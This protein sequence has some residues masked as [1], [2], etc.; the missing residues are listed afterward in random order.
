LDRDID[1]YPD[2]FNF[3]VKFN[4][5]SSSILRTEV[6]KNGVKQTVNEKFRGAPR[7]HITKEFRNVKYIKLDNVVLP[8]FTKLEETYDGYD[9]DKEK[10]LVNDRFVS[11]VIKE[12]DTNRILCTSDDSIRIDEDTGEETT[13]PCP[14]AMIFPEKLLGTNFFTGTPYY[15]SVYYKNSQLNN[16]NSLTIQFYDDCGKP[17]KYNNL[18]TI[19]ELNKAEEDGM[20]ISTSDIRHPLNR[21]LQ[22]HVSFIIGVIESQINTNTKF[23]N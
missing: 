10:W 15:G 21:R 4:P 9:F 17:L 1:T 20:P 12:L 7:P 6:N 22:V 19:K 8:Q 3:T 18:Y 11:L 13:P 2:P 5:S 16:L 14:F 23:E